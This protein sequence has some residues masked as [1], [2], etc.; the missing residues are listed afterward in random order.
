MEWGGGEITLNPTQ[1]QVRLGA[2]ER[3]QHEAAFRPAREPG[4]SA[5]NLEL[6][7][8]DE[9][10]QHIRQLQQS[11]LRV[12]LSRPASNAAAPPLLSPRLASPGAE[13]PT[14]EAGQNGVGTL[15]DRAEIR[16]GVAFVLFPP[17]SNVVLRV[18]SS[19]PS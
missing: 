13:P 15:L 6:L 18:Q 1:R 19:M 16:R 3:H 17:V 5:V 7:S 10:G 9:Q 2:I 11:A 4:L 8:R 14:A 12:A